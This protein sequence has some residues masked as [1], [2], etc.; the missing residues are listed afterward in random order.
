M[1]EILAHHFGHS[2]DDDKA[3]A[4][5][6][7][8][9]ERAQSRW[10]NTEALAFFELAQQRLLAMP[11]TD[12]N[13]LRRV[14]LV[15][16]QA[17]VRFA[18]G[19]HAGQLAALEAIGEQISPA[20]DPARRAAWHYWS[21]FLN[22]T[23]GGAADRSVDHCLQASS[24]AQ[25]AGLEDLGA[26]AD[27]CLAQVY[28]IAGELRKA[29]ETGE[30]ALEVSERRGNRWWACRTLAQL[31]PAANALGEWQRSLAYCARTLE[32]GSAMNDLR[33][34]VLAYIR[35]ASTQ[36]QRGDWHAGL[37]HCDQ[38]QALAPGS[39]M[40]HCARSAATG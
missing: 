9:A 34:K 26:S 18:L 37:A 15:I 22:S 25:A 27:S 31:S 10:A 17:E 40:R 23:T 5:A 35:L 19:Q 20:D 11:A 36:I 33:L 39:T 32:H 13:R 7:R 4:Y 21:G 3:V 8:A 14:D 28:L 1:V 30:R 16:K 24:I 2:E 12:A 6:M 29:I 38:A